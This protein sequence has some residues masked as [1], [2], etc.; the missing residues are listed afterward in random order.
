M[1]AATAL[2]RRRCEAAEAGGFNLDSAV[3]AFVPRG[4]ERQRVDFASTAESGM[5]QPWALK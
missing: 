4:H 1:V 2:F 5:K 3:A